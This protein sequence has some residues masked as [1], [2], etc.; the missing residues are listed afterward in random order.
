MEARPAARSWEF[1]DDISST[2]DASYDLPPACNYLDPSSR[3]FQ[4]A[5]L[6]LLV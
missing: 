2:A 4:S 1:S 3:P 6:S 5:T